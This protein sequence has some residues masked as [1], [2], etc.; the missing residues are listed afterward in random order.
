MNT[1]QTPLST[2]YASKEM[3]HLFSSQFKYSTWRKLWAALAKAQKNLGLPISSAQVAELE[4]NIDNIDFAV[5]AK[6]EKESRH[7]VMAHIYAYGDECPAA[8]PIIHLGATSSYV[9]DNTDLIQMKQG[10]KLL[11]SKLVIVIEQLNHF[12]LKHAGERCL[13]YTHLQPAQ[14]T[15]VGKRAALWLQDLATDFNDLQKLFEDFPFLGVKGAT[16]SQAAFL[17]LFHGDHDKVIALDQAIATEMG[18]PNTYVIAS[19]TYP[20]KLDMRVLSVLAGLGASAHKFGNDMRLLAHMNEIDEPFESKQIGSSAMPYKRNPMKSERICSLARYL[21]SQWE[22][23][24]YTASLQWLERTLDDSANRRMSIAESFLTA[25]SILTLISSVL[26]GI[27]VNSKVVEKNLLKH[28]PFMATEMIL[29][30]AVH[31]GKDRQE[32]HEKLRVHSHAASALIKEGEES[33]LLER[34]AND[35]SIDLSKEEI[36][37]LLQTKNFVGRSKE[38]TIE[39]LKKE[40]APLLLTHPRPDRT[41][42]SVEI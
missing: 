13:A 25:D 8:K 10:L 4:K 11:K 9:M 35:S 31:K 36:D 33:D 32:V 29:M 5:A 15:T 23:P 26:A 22:N 21:I 2:R 42:P 14:P 38:Q 28:L 12:A 39:F 7:E 41:I 24:A 18:F 34:I 1:Y 17:A 3:K 30:E 20:R 19:Q 6:Y 16:G 37:T 40:I 27:T